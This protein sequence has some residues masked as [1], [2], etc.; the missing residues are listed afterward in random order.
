MATTG[1]IELHSSDGLYCSV[2]I[3][4]DASPDEIKSHWFTYC[5]LVDNDT[6]KHQG[7][8]NWIYVATNFITYLHRVMYSHRDIIECN[9]VAICPPNCEWD[10]IYRYKIVPNEERYSQSEVWLA[11]AT[12]FEIIKG[13]EG[14]DDES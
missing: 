4:T 14:E 12:T 6:G 2:F 3:G 9:T 8:L 13:S 7:R 10:S 5:A 11:E 1:I